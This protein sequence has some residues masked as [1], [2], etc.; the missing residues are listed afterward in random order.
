MKKNFIKTLAL[1]S[2]L[3]TFGYVSAKEYVKNDLT[4]LFTN[5]EAI[6]Y[7]INMRSFNADDKNG[8]GIVEL[9]LGETPGNFLNAINRLDE[10]QSYGINAIHLMPINPVGKLKAIGT[11]GSV[12][13]MNDIHSIDARL[14]DPKSKLSVNE[15]AKKF[16]DE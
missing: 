13:A 2:I 16:V 5:N 11:V 6:I 4:T 9:E 8:N 15:Q 1:I 12:Y 10:L 3:N 7:E 14:A